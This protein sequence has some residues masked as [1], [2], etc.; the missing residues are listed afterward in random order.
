MFL[1]TVLPLL[2]LAAVAEADTGPAHTIEPTDPKAD[3]VPACVVF[4]VTQA[5]EGKVN[6]LLEG[7]LDGEHWVSLVAM[8]ELTTA[9][10]RNELRQVA[11]VPRFLR[12]SIDPTGGAT[13]TGVVQLGSGARLHC[14]VASPPGEA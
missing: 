4:H 11:F 9:G 14:K 12:A 10:T 13:A 8:T 3:E 6:A 5:G 1:R 2:V 7:S